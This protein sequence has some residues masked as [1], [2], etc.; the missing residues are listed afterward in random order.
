MAIVDVL[1]SRGEI[2]VGGEREI[3]CKSSM[4][5]VYRNSLDCDV[6]TTFLLPLSTYL[7]RSKCRFRCRIVDYLRPPEISRP[8]A[9]IEVVLSELARNQGGKYPLGSM[10]LLALGDLAASGG[11]QYSHGEDLRGYRD[12]TRPSVIIIS[13][14]MP[15]PPYNLEGTGFIRLIAFHLAVIP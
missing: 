9:F 5:R 15:E 1:N 7:V 11:K 4:T 2:I 13:L 14:N 8:L 6:N 12:P 3:G 10:Q